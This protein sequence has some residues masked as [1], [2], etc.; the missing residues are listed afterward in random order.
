M[1]ATRPLHNLSTPSAMPASVVDVLC[2]GRGEGE[3]A[4]ARPGGRNRRAGAG[5]VVRVSMSLTPIAC[6]GQA[7]TQSPQSSQREPSTTTLPSTR[8]RASRGQLS[9]QV[10]QPQHSPSSMYMNTPQLD[11][12]HIYIETPESCIV[13]PGRSLYRESLG[14]HPN[15]FRAG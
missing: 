4:P 5:K 7:S 13:K 10:P 2:T 9:R 15:L 3:D 8:R 11:A 6:T 12:N 14:S 1:I